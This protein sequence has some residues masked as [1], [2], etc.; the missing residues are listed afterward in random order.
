V[1]DYFLPVNGV[2]PGGAF[3]LALYCLYIDGLLWAD[4]LLWALSK[5]RV[6]CYIGDN[7]VGALA[8]ADD[9]VLL[10]PTASA[11]CAV[12]D[13]CDKYASDYSTLFNASKSQC[14]VVLPGSR[15]FYTSIY[16]MGLFPIFLYWEY[17]HRFCYSFVNFGH[18][19]SQQ[20]RQLTDDNDIFKRWNAFVE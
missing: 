12:L 9:V 2:K 5:A 17:P 14:L 7:F 6:R 8:Y 20:S 19:M 3:S 1:A 11:L 13:S 15:P 10:A 16:T 18:V 4:D